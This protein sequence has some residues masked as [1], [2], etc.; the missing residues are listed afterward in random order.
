MAIQ[1]GECED[2]RTTRSRFR[3][4]R[5]H[6]AT[7]AGPDSCRSRARWASDT[8]AKYVRCPPRSVQYPLNCLS[9]STTAPR[10]FRPS[11]LI[12][13]FLKRIPRKPGY[14]EYT[15]NAVISGSEMKIK[16]RNTQPVGN[17]TWKPATRHRLLNIATARQ[18]SWMVSW[19]NQRITDAYRVS[20]PLLGTLQM[21]C[22]RFG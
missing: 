18:K 21:F 19:L 8:F 20:A 10:T 6:S 3:F 15:A 22:S 11:G 14:C 16:H 13:F 7:I 17:R 1:R 4:E 5:S 2:T 12:E 9:T